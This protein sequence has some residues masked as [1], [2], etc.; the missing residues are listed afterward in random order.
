MVAVISWRGL[1][2]LTLSVMIAATVT[3]VSDVLED[4]HGIPPIGK[5]LG[6]P[7]I[8]AV[9]LAVTMGGQSFK[10]SRT[11]IAFVLAYFAATTLSVVF[12]QHPEVSLERLDELA[13]NLLLVML[14]MLVVRD[15]ATMRWALRSFYLPLAL[16]ALA[17]VVSAATGYNDSDQT[18]FLQAEYKT[19]VGL[20][21]TYRAQGPFADPNSFGRVLLA[22]VPLTLPDIVVPVRSRVWRLIGLVAAA[23]L[24]AGLFLTYSRGAILGLAVTA[25]ALVWWFRQYWLGLGIGAIAVAAIILVFAPQGYLDRIARVPTAFTEADDTASTGDESIVNRADEMAL[26]VRMF[27]ENPVVGVGPGNYKE[28]FQKYS[29]DHYGIPRQE[30]REAHSFPLEVAAET[31]IFGLMAFAAVLSVALIGIVCA[32]ARDVESLW[33]ARAV[34]LGVLG[35]FAA[36]LVL[37]D[38]YSRIAWLLIAFGL[39]RVGHPASPFKRVYMRPAACEA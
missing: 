30:D 24:I 29:L 7:F 11:A 8:V 14:V 2:T 10:A 25:V 6:L 27:A 9:G 12:A 23:A 4:F 21:D 37:H 3:N 26:A 1:V 35:Y 16:I 39:A 32:D 15:A 18:G 28:L 5:L 13:R 34:G 22:A 38:D 17:C 20:V 33:L 36:S 19:L 31:G